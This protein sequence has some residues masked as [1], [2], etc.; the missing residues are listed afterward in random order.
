MALLLH[1]GLLGGMAGEAGG[2]DGSGEGA[3]TLAAPPEGFLAAP[4]TGSSLLTSSIYACSV[5]SR[6]TRAWRRH[7]G[8]DAGDAASDA[9]SDAADA[10]VAHYGGSRVVGHKVR[11][12]NWPA[13]L[14]MIVGPTVQS[15]CP[16]CR[17]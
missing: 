12:N 14:A 3:W 5:P 11:M 13:E 1:G 6:A 7:C 2:A 4:E 9:A 16:C 8:G 10:D 15:F 17:L